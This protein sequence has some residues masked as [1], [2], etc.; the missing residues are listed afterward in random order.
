M[1]ASTLAK[2]TL[3]LS[4]AIFLGTALSVSAG[5]LSSS[6]SG[7][8]RVT[9]EAQ[10]RMDLS[11]LKAELDNATTATAALGAQTR[12][13]LSSRANSAATASVG[14][15]AEF[16]ATSRAGLAAA[17]SVAERGIGTISD[18]VGSVFGSSEVSAGGFG[19][20]GITGNAG[21]SSTGVGGSVGV[22][23]DAGVGAGLG[24][25][26]GAGIGLGG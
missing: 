16:L 2:R 10:S 24:A 25:G 4:S 8:G 13:T 18:T 9:A 1:K 12:G 23:A 11:D 3:T 20:A 21:A 6:L 19:G 26:V 17:V 22:G 14:L 5:D 7:E 15:G